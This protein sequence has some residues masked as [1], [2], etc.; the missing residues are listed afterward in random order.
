MCGLTG[1]MGRVDAD[2]KRAFTALLVLA[3]SRGVDASGVALFRHVKGKRTWNVFKDKVAASA[4]VATKEYQEVLQNRK[5]YY[6]MGHTRAFTD[7]SPLNN[8]NNHPIITGNVVGTHN[9]MIFNAGC[10]FDTLDLPRKNQVDSEILFQIANSA[11]SDKG[12]D[13]QRFRE[14][15]A[16][17]SGTLAIVFASLLC[18]RVYLL[19]DPATPLFLARNKKLRLMMYSS[20]LP[21]LRGIST[22]L[23]DGKW[24]FWEFP[25]EV[26]FSVDPVK[27]TW[28]RYKV[29]L[30]IAG[31]YWTSWR[32]HRD[33]RD[34]DMDEM[35]YA[36]APTA[37]SACIAISVQESDPAEKLDIVV[38]QQLP[39]GKKGVIYYAFGRATSDN[40]IVYK[41]G[42]TV[43]KVK[44]QGVCIARSY[45]RDTLTDL[46]AELGYWNTTNWYVG[47]H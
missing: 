2:A 32:G 7:G 1:I 21:H 41:S 26:L 44:N 33:W 5:T 27:L 16:K 24:E 20:V 42:Q 12:I 11:I 15:M 30:P 47:V 19:T 46:C 3:E 37:K 34:D 39:M 13:L 38:G 43:P 18:P 8:G 4:L 25:E 40:A 14:M 28:K 17:C 29:N 31:R 23:R 10:L 35:D 36:P 45:H 22:M 6:L 9:G